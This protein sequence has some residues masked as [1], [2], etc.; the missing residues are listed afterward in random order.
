MKTRA[1]IV[2]AVICLSPLLA[3]AAEYAT[4]TY[5]SVE[6]REL[7]MHIVSPDG[8]AANGRAGWAFT[9]GELLPWGTRRAGIWRHPPPR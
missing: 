3:G 5:K 1:G 9:P 7:R 8:H 2:A 4:A 6:D